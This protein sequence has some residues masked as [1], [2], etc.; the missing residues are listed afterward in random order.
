MHRRL[1]PV[2]RKPLQEI[3][4]IDNQR[5]RLRRRIEPLVGARENL[6]AARV[7]LP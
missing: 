6:Q 1:E 5:A 2:I 3:A 4:N 7:V